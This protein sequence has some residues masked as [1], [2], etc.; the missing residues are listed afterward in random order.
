MKLFLMTDLEGV[1]GVINGR[2]YLTPEGRYHETARRLLTD[3][4][5]AA[6]DGFASEGFTD[7]LV[8]DGHG[9]GA[10]DIERLDPRARLQRGWGPRPYPFGLS[11]AFDAMAYVGQH[12]K[13]GTPYSHLTHT[14][15]WSIENQTINGLSIGE[16]GEGALCAGELGV[17]VIFAAGEKALCE[18]AQALTPW[19]VTVAVL[20]GVCPGSGDGLTGEEYELFHVGAIH[21]QPQKACELI[22]QQSAQAGRLFTR[23]RPRNNSQFKPLKLA[24]PYSLVRHRRAYRGQ[25]AKSLT[26]EHASSLIDLFNERRG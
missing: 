18:E 6:I 1:A 24:P 16:Y 21:L 5:N 25:P 15:W 3:E 11:A 17:P 9:A 2:D 4:V 20:E 19:A 10:I 26:T 8:A 13:A 14:G 23:N 22:R 7:F 12:A